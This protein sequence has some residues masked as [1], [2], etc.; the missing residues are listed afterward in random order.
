MRFPFQYFDIPWVGTIMITT[1]LLRL[2]IF[3]TVVASQ[4]NAAKM[5]EVYPQMAVLQE[6]MTEAKQRGDMYEQNMLGGELQKLMQENNVSPLKN[7]WPI[8]IQAPF[9]ISMFLGLRGMA[10]LPVPSFETESFLWITDLTLRDPYYL[11]PA[12]ITATMYLQFYL[13]ADG[14]NLQNMGPIA[15]GVMKVLPLGLFFI[16]FKFPAV[17]RIIRLL[18]ERLF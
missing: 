10:N 18:F 14:A 9:F 15:K 7:F 6:K 2:F 4:K 1:L 17:N 13:A 3:P 5:N 8:L 11:T 16:C 12:F